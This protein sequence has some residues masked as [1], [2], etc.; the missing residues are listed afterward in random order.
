MKRLVVVAP[1]MN[2]LEVMPHS[3]AR[4]QCKHKATA[5]ALAGA[6]LL[7]VASCAQVQ[8]VETDLCAKI[9][10]LPPTVVATLDAQDPH[11]AL[12]TLWAYQKSACVMGQ[13]AAG[14]A[15]GFGAMIWGEL[16]VLIPQLLPQL[17]PFLV[18]L[19]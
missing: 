13:P 7:A 18:G 3:E 2:R 15:A 9:A 10:V 14:V 6:A 16:K 8:S 4:L 12:G 17:I 19:L 5:L 11:S 1:D